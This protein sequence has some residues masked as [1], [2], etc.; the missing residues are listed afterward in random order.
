MQERRGGGGWHKNG[1]RNF[2]TFNFDITP[3]LINAILLLQL[4][5]RQSTRDQDDD[6]FVPALCLAKEG[7]GGTEGQCFTLL[8]GP[9]RSRLTSTHCAASSSSLEIS[10][11]GASKL[12]DVPLLMPQEGRKELAPENTNFSSGQIQYSQTHK[13]IVAP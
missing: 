12:S 10:D 1:R 4:S 11:S 9:P 13:S 7:G 2:L 3:D 6:F 8:Y 5:H